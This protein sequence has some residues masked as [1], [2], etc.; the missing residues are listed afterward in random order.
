M[1]SSLL[2]SGVQGG[3]K[4]WV[5]YSPTHCVSYQLQTEIKHRPNF[6]NTLSFHT[7]SGKKFQF[8]QAEEIKWT[9]SQVYPEQA[10]T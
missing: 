4:V 6:Q 3:K 1:S 2:Y 5:F 10:I 8:T 9:L 7:Y